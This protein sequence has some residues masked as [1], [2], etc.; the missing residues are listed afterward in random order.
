MYAIRSYY[1]NRQIAEP[2]VVRGD[3]EPGRV[4]GA[5]LR[6]RRFEGFGVVVPVRA[7]RVVSFADLP[8]PGGV[9]DPRPE[10]FQLLVRIDVQIELEA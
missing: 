6:K 7:L 2:L 4:L 9:V 1:G 5:A 3:D 10:A 8:V